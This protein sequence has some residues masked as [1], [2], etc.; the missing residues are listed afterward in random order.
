MGASFRR[1]QRVAWGE[2]DSAGIVF[3][4]NYFRWFDTATHELFRSIGL[5]LRELEQRGYLVPILSVSAEFRRS[6]RY[7][8]EFTIDSTVAEVE[9]KTFRVHHQVRSA[10]GKSLSE[11]T[12][13][14]GWVGK[15]GDGPH[16]LPIPAEYRELLARGGHVAAHS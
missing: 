2:T 3:Y 16:L 13:L 6:L 15:G 1:T 4:P 9:E 10:E 8:D 12:E 5:P 7:D 14:R 11:G